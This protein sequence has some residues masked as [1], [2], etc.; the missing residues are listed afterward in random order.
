MRGGGW[1]V[2][3]DTLV[4]ADARRNEADWEDVVGRERSLSIDR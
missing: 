2:F 3:E 4:L 1:H